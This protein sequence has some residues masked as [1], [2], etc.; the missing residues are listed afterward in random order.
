MPDPVHRMIA[1]PPERMV[2]QAIGQLKGKS[3]IP[4]ARVTEA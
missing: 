1:I 4:L 2:S 3:A